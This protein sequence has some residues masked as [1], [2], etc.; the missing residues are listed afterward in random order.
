M[1]FVPLVV[2]NPA[3]KPVLVGVGV[4]EVGGVR[5]VPGRVTVGVD[6]SRSSRSL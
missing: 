4:V 2:T 1:N 3:G 5:V 6:R